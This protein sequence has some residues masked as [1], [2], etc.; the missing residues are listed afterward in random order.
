MANDGH[1]GL[2]TRHDVLADQGRDL[3][4]LLVKEP[5]PVNDRPFKLP[6]RCGL[7]RRILVQVIVLVY[8]ELYVA[9]NSHAPTPRD[10]ARLINRP[11]YSI[12]I[13]PPLETRSCSSDHDLLKCTAAGC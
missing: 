4:C 11:R 9:G 2:V 13:R 5:R 12:K 3:P 7:G 10:L 1:D 8:R 6:K